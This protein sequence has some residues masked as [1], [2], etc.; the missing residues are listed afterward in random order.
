MRGAGR[1]AR[2]KRTLDV[3]VG[4][5]LTVICAPI[6]ALV[7]GYILV[8]SGRPVIFR[9]TRVGQ[10]GRLFTMLKFR[11]MVP[12]AESMRAGLCDE[13]ATSGVQSASFKMQSDPRI[14]RGGGLLRRWSLDELPQ[15][16]NVVGGSMSLV[17]PRPHTVEDFAEYREG[18]YERLDVPP[19]LTGPWRVGGRCELSGDEAPELD[20][21]YVRHGSIIVDVS[22]LLRTMK[23]VVS[24]RGAM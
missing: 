6:M 3:V 7:A 11:T 22:L 12:D 17:G 21:D 13:R 24:G 5:C 10:N 18:T 8:T 15:L 9:Q 14:C 19:G 4:S 16:I 20:L 23:A 1:S 2:A